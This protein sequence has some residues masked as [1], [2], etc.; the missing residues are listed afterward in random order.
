MRRWLPQEFSSF[1]TFPFVNIHVSGLNLIY[2]PVHCEYNFAITLHVSTPWTQIKS[3][4]SYN[5]HSYSPI[6]HSFLSSLSLDS[7]CICIY[8]VFYQML[9]FVQT[10][11]VFFSMKC[12]LF[13]QYFFSRKA[14]QFI[15]SLFE[16]L[17]FKNVLC[18]GTPRYCFSIN[19][20]W[21]L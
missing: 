11:Y 6:S 12:F 9:C 19:I 10:V 20:I 17:G 21:L 7:K 2:I 5:P 8:I 18:V 14:T 15:A 1:K 13:Q 4:F 3:K 16:D